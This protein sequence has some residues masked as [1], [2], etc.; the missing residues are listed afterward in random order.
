M[1]IMKSL[2]FILTTCLLLNGF[3]SLATTGNEAT[4]Y[5]KYLLELEMNTNVKKMEKAWKKR[6]S[7]WEDECKSATD[8]A[9]LKKL[10]D[11]FVNNMGEDAGSGVSFSGVDN[12]TSFG[13]HLSKLGASMSDEAFNSSWAGRKDSWA[14]EIVKLNEAMAAKIKAEQLKGERVTLKT[15]EFSE[16]FKKVWAATKP[17]FKSIIGERTSG[18]YKVNYIIPQGASARITSEEDDSKPI[19]TYEVVF[20]AGHHEENAAQLMADMSK[21]IEP[22]MPE[23]YHVNISRIEGGY[24]NTTRHIFEYKSDKFA[25]TARRPVARLGIK[26]VGDKYEV[27]L[28]IQE[29]FF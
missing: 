17:A 5:A 14:G 12:L 16:G 18:S 15:S 28:S 23:G 19:H 21:A 25:E 11:E 10:A 22:L 1:R 4:S 2:T 9:A 13:D 29:P 3:V 8:L 24:V 6:K 20:D 26:K 27:E 7:D